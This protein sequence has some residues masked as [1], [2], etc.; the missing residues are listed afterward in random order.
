MKIKKKNLN[1]FYNGEQENIIF[2][3]H[4]VKKESVNKN[5]KNEESINA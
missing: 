2:K 5:A 4:K 3:K 1:D